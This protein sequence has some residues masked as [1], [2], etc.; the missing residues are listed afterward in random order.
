MPELPEV[1][2]VKRGL[3]NILNDKPRILEFQLLRENLRDP[4]PVAELKK[5]EGARITGVQR[6]AKYLIFLTDRGNFLSHLGMTG[7][8][9]SEADLRL[10]SSPRLH[11]HVRIFLNNGS[12]LIYNDP[13]RFGIL[14]VLNAATEKKRLARLGPEPLAKEFSAVVLW[15]SLRNKNC[16]I[17]TAIMDQSVVV[18]VGNIYASE[19]LFYA[20]IKPHTRASRLSCARAGGLVQ[21]IQ[22][23]LTK[24]IAAGGS[25]ISD[26]R[27]AEGNAGSFQS[28]FAVYDRA[29]QPCAKCTK[30]IKKGV[31][32][33]RSTFWCSACQR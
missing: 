7:S 8:W 17:K 18:G 12:T 9:R 2:I 31:T 33:G 25:T 16:G 22:S 11:D 15:K 4:F 27:N 3:E 30:P 6:R 21:A 19:S 5:M 1:E 13:R 32:V 26:Y 29:D 14:D 28:R 20:G 24:S 10:G 23:V